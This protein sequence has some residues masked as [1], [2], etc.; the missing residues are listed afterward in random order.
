M[1][2]ML[3]VFVSDA[4]ARPAGGVLLMASH[5]FVVPPAPPVQLASR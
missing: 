3:V 4:D 2:S 5:R 1:A